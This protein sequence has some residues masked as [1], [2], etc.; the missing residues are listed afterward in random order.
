MPFFTKK[1]SLGSLSLLLI[2]VWIVQL[3][4]ASSESIGKLGGGLDELESNKIDSFSGSASS[5][6]ITS[7]S[8]TSSS[9]LLARYLEEDTDN[10]SDG[11]DNDETKTQEKGHKKIVNS[12]ALLF[13]CTSLCFVIFFFC[14]LRAVVSVRYET[15]SDGPGSSSST[16]AIRGAIIGNLSVFQRRA[17]LDILFH[18]DQ[19]FA[20]THAQMKGGK[21]AV[22]LGDG[23]YHSKDGND[24]YNYDK[25]NT[26][27]DSNSNT[28]NDTDSDKEKQCSNLMA[29]PSKKHMSNDEESPSPGPLTPS[30]HHM[31][32]PSPDS[33]HHM[34]SLENSPSAC[35]PVTSVPMPTLQR[36]H[37]SNLNDGDH[38]Q[39]NVTGNGAGNVTGTGTGTGAIQMVLLQPRL[40]YRLNT[41]SSG[42]DYDADMTIHLSHPLSTGE[43]KQEVAVEVSTLKAKANTNTDLND[44]EV[45]S[46]EDENDKEDAKGD[47]YS[48]KEEDLDEESILCSICLD[49]YGTS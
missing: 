34:I 2:L 30:T 10:D 31:S 43:E 41:K 27:R 19:K 21:H 23:S 35:S 4:S 25:S 47:K 20:D 49:T 14:C 12:Q 48:M 9:D 8:T 17:I 26:K 42:T 6:T 46:M 40:Q 11:D 32:S 33:S 18:D 22:M 45:A 3:A 13:I 16:D 24:K 28:R 15:V 7:T 44:K 39:D 37:L 36:G 1:R 5:I 29:T 38:F